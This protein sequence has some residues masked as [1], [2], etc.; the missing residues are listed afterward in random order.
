MHFTIHDPGKPVFGML[1]QI[2]IF[3]LLEINRFLC[4]I[5]KV[6]KTYWIY[7]QRKNL[8]SSTYESKKQDAHFLE[9]IL[10]FET[11]GKTVAVIPLLHNEVPGRLWPQKAH[12]VNSSKHCASNCYKVTVIRNFPLDF[13]HYLNKPP[14]S[15]SNPHRAVGGSE[16]HE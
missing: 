6:F 12:K 15:I 10:W 14:P 4:S 2:S 7:K 9:Q 13:I 16:A 5:W 3:F 11:L 1:P 8:L